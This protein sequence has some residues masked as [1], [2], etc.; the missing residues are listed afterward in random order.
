MNLSTKQNTSAGLPG[1]RSLDLLFLLVLFVLVCY[2]LLGIAKHPSLPAEDAIMIL[3]YAQHLSQ[4]H[5]IVYNIGDP[6]VDGATDFLFV[7]AIAC[8]TKAGLSV[9]IAARSIIMAS[10]LLTVLLV[11]AALR[12]LHNTSPWFALFA[13]IYLAVGPALAYIAALFGT[14]FYALFVT[15][16]WCFATRMSQV[17]ETKRSS[18]GFAFCCLGMTL[19][20]PDGFLLSLGMLLSLL[21]WQGLPQNR[22]TLIAFCGVI[23]GLGGA[24]F[25]WH[26]RY[27][28]YPLP[29]PYYIKGHGLLHLDGLRVSLGGVKALCGVFLPIY[30]VALWRRETRRQAVFSLIPV[31]GF[32]LI[33]ILI[34]SEMNWW[35]R[36]QYAVLPIVL[37]STPPL[38]ERVWE[39][40]R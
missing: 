39:A 24:Y 32:S 30:L 22:Q 29:N 19:T 35:E 31:V 18:I 14:P 4:G 9:E 36:F 26:W 21:Y 23:G 6:P 11:Y 1:F 17:G 33:W 7:I 2:Y 38:L 20:R 10:H 34:S 12:K 40:W 15:L 37:L 13:G 28:G 8:V 27:F 5:G 16:A 3:R 25:L